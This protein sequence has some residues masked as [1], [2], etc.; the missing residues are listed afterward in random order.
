MLPSIADEVSKE[1]LVLAE[2]RK[3]GFKTVLECECVFFTF[4]CLSIGFITFRANLGLG[5]SLAPIIF[6]ILI[7]VGNFFEGGD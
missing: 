6:R 5:R 7:R 4:G 1:V 3:L 2:W